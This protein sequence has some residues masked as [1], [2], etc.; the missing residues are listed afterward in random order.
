MIKLLKMFSLLIWLVLGLLT[1]TAK[2]DITKTEYSLCWAMTM[3]LIIISL[4]ET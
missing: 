3:L 1:L 4:G 2:R